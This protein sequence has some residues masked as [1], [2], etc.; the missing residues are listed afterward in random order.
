MTSVSTQMNDNAH[1][2]VC[3][4]SDTCRVGTNCTNCQKYI[5]ADCVETWIPVEEMDN[6]GDDYPFEG[7][8]TCCK[9]CDNS[10]IANGI[11]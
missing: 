11:W 5:C 1:C 10:D 4:V 2:T 7:D 9:D 8:V 6:V 3:S